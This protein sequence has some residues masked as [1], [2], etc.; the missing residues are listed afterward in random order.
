MFFFSIAFSHARFCFLTSKMKLCI[1]CFWVWIQVKGYLM[2]FFLNGWT[3]FCKWVPEEKIQKSKVWCL[4]S[5]CSFNF[6]RFIWDHHVLFVVNLSTLHFKSTVMLNCWPNGY[7]WS[8]YFW[9][10]FGIHQ[11]GFSVEMLCWLY[12]YVRECINHELKFSFPCV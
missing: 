8:S 10:L 5:R 9:S 2:F 4:F 6:V 3:C 1:L 12:V 7:C 11:S